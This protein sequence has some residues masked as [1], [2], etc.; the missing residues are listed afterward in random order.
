MEAELGF[1]MT[2]EGALSRSRRQ[3]LTG[4]VHFVFSKLELMNWSIFFGKKTHVYHWYKVEFRCSRTIDVPE[5]RESGATV[6]EAVVTGIDQ[7]HFTCKFT[8]EIHRH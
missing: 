6:V 8:S 4:E 3:R 7:S 1:G 2:Q 5:L